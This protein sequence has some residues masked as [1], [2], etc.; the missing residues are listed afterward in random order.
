MRSEP[1]P[2]DG[3]LWGEWVRGGGA[4]WD[5]VRRSWTVFMLN[6][7]ELI[8]LLRRPRD[9]PGLALQLMNIDDPAI[10]APF[11]DELDQRLVNHINSAVTLVAHTGRLT[12]YFR[13]DF[14]AMVA[15][16]DRRNAAIMAME[17][18]TFLRDLRNYLL[19]YGPAPIIQT[20]TVSDVQMTHT[21]KLSATK[22]LEWGEWKRAESYLRSFAD[23]DGPVIGDDVAAYSTEMIALYMWLFGQRQVVQ[24]APPDRLRA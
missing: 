5:I 18:A 24:D 13:P 3:H 17:Q 11:W 19:K 10:T 21:L 23:G 4:R 14:P 20:L 6:T 15:E 8:R 9:D 22:L 16:Y 1:P 7:Q 12:K 2:L